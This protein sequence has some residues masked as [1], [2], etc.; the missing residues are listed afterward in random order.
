[1]VPKFVLRDFCSYPYQ[2]NNA[3][4]AVSLHI[5]NQWSKYYSKCKRTWKICVDIF[6]I[7]KTLVWITSV[8]PSSRTCFSRTSRYVTS[9]CPVTSLTLPLACNAHQKHKWNVSLQKTYS[10]ITTFFTSS[11]SFRYQKHLKEKNH[12]F[13]FG[14]EPSFPCSNRKTS[15]I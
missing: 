14:T 2:H 3:Y 15:R 1:M 10:K 8:H 9:T 13:E 5:G 7:C 12:K 4:T 11:Q 6:R